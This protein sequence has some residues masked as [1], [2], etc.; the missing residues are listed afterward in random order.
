MSNSHIDNLVTAITNKISS[1]IGTHNTSS[2][3]HSTTHYTQTQVDTAL[4]KKKSHYYGTCSTSASTQTK[5]VTST[6]FV[7]ETG[8]VISVKFTNGNTYNGTAK[9]NINNGAAVDVSTVGATKTSRYYWVSG[10]V[11]TFVYDGTNFVMLEGGTATTTYYGVTKLNDTVTSTS[12]SLSATANS[13]KTAYDKGVEAYNLAE[14]KANST[15]NHQ[16]YDTKLNIEF[17]PFVL[18]DLMDEGYLSSY[19]DKDIGVH[20]YEYIHDFEPHGFGSANLNTHTIYLIY[21][22][23]TVVSNLI[24][25]GNFSLL[26]KFIF[27]N[28]E[29]RTNDFEDTISHEAVDYYFEEVGHTLPYLDDEY[30]K[31]NHNHTLSNITDLTIEQQTI[32]VTSPTNG[33]DYFSGGTREINA[34][35]YGKLVQVYVNFY[36]VSAKQGSTS[37]DTVIGKL[38]SGWE[39][40]I[41]VK[42]KPAINV[43]ANGHYVQ[44][45]VNSNGNII[46]RLGSTNAMSSATFRGTMTFIT[47]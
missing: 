3:A 43:N 4:A 42:I 12:T 2:A 24:S 39:P 28:A 17:L 16:E 10:E 47:E 20:L 19:H 29:N 45:G 18:K 46:L 15:H 7:L 36:N 41:G 1:L 26:R 40:K 38:P 13:V 34:V 11:V 5:V 14:G 6:D 44:M 21:E 23:D 32:T 27:I 9:L 37:T 35:R 8:A 33:T 30:A 31:T 25:S 22:N